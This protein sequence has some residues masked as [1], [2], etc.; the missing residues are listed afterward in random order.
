MLFALSF[1]FKPIISDA[2]ATAIQKI[3][4]ERMASMVGK[5]VWP[6]LASQFQFDQAYVVI[7]H[8]I[9]NITNFFLNYLLVAQYIVQFGWDGVTKVKN[10]SAST[11]NC[12]HDNA[13]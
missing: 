3:G 13:C 4:L 1:G 8:L 11:T 9:L 2:A 7:Q 6:S 12:Q 5:V 10:A